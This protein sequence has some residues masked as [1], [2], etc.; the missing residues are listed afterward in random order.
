MLKERVNMPYDISAS[1]SFIAVWN[2]F[3]RAF[4]HDLGHDGYSDNDSK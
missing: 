2:F 1:V 3:S 4:T